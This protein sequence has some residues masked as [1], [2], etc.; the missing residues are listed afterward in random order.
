MVDSAALPWKP[1]NEMSCWFATPAV[2]LFWKVEFDT[3]KLVLTFDSV[4]DGLVVIAAELL[5]FIVQ[6]SMVMPSIEVTND[7][8][9]TPKP[10]PERFE[11]VT[12]TFEMLPMR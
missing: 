1:K 7:A 5:L 4:P 12:E 9:R 6:L 11:F 3:V 8:T 10:L 2:L